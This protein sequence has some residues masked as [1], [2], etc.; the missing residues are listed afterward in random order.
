MKLN[1]SVVAIVAAVG[2]GLSACATSGDVERLDAK[3]DALAKSTD[4]RIAAAEQRAAAAEAAQRV[5][6]RDV[7][8]HLAD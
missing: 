4:S 7:G 8:R 1:R 3:I 5:E 2:L 6:H